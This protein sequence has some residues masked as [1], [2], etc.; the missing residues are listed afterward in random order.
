M[1]RVKRLLSPGLVVAALALV[2]ALGGTAVADRAGS[3]VK[4]NSITSA[5]IKNGTI[6]AADIH[7]KT[8]R[9]LRRSGRRITP[10]EPSPGPAGRQGPKGDPG[11][12]GPPGQSLVA[13]RLT[14]ENPAF[15]NVRVVA[16]PRIP[17]D[18]LGPSFDEGE[19]LFEDVELEQGTYLVQGT[20]QFFDF[21]AQKGG[22][23]GVARIF[24]NGEPEATSWSPFIPLDGNN[25]AQASGAVLVRVPAGGGTLSVQAVVRDDNNATAHAGGNLIVTRLAE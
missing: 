3:K 14:P 8:L 12:Q 25:A 24:L 4:R 7:P 16:I 23:Y 13:D 10:A 21:D 22:G 5:H 15:G 20:V 18:S 19:R 6:R 1:E 2:F 9:S 11:P 17:E